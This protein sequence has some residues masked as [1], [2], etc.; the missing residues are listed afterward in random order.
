MSRTK[1]LGGNESAST[2]AAAQAVAAAA[3]GGCV[4]PNDPTVAQFQNAYNNDPNYD[5]TVA[6]WSSTGGMITASSMLDGPTIAALAACGVQVTA[7]NGSSNGGGTDN[8]G[9]GGTSQITLAQAAQNLVSAL[10][11]GCS[12]SFIPACST[13]QS[14]WN[15]SGGSP[16]AVDGNYGPC[17]MAALNSALGGSGAPASCFPGTCSGGNYVAPQGGGTNPVPVPTSPVAPNWKSRKS[18]FLLTAMGGSVGSAGGAL[19]GHLVKKQGWG[20]AIG[21][22]LGCAVTAAVVTPSISGGSSS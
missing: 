3:Q 15:A 5:Q 9:G 6:P 13:F 10:A 20:A 7:C 14:A 21:A 16:L 2:D 17:T 22:V 18:A 4:Q 8:G 1:T 19:L 11:G 12:Q